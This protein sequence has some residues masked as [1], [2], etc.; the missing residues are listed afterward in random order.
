MQTEKGE[1]KLSLFA[2]CMMLYTENPNGYTKDWTIVS[3]RVP[4]GERKEGGAKNPEK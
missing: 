3:S 1:M 2:N 4:E